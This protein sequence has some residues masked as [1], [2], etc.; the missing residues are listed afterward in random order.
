MHIDLRSH[1]LFI[2]MAILIGSGVVAYVLYTQNTRHLEADQVTIQ[3]A[4]SSERNIY[5]SSKAAVTIVEFSDYQC[6]YCSRL[7]P[8]LGEIVDESEGTIAWE[9]RHLPLSIHPLAMPA[10]VLAECLAKEKGNKAFWEFT[11]MVFANQTGLSED[12]LDTTA[13]ELGL[14]QADVIECESDPG[15]KAQIISDMTASETLGG[16]GTPFSV[17]VYPDNTYKTV[18]GAVPKEA[19]IE[20]LSSYVE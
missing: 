15:I 9:Y 1:S 6:P 8:T 17:I 11:D 14:S 12:F 13:I 7:H 16:S 4:I 3:R 10:A 19:W 18:S 20:L 2:V 5:G